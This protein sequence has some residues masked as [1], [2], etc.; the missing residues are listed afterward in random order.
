MW[1]RF[2]KQP[3]LAE[4]IPEM[5][6]IGCV[7]LAKMRENQTDSDSKNAIREASGVMISKKEFSV[8]NALTQEEKVRAVSPS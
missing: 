5:V 8:V 6:R 3:T 7:K 2:A 1:H 4:M